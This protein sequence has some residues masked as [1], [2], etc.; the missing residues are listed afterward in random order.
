MG[1]IECSTLSIGY[2]LL[3]KICFTFKN[4]I[5]SLA[6]YYFVPFSDYL[7]SGR[8]RVDRSAFRTFVRFAL[9]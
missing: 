1:R 8:E 2:V 3:V 9:V 6:L 4:F 5:F 7:A